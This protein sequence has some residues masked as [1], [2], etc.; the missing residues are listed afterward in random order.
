MLG[1]DVAGDAALRNDA[2]DAG[3]GAGLLAQ[4]V[5]VVERLDDRIQRVDAHLRF[6]GRMGRSAEEFELDGIHGQRLAALE[7][8]HAGGVA[9]H[10]SV[11]IAEHALVGIRDLGAVRLLRGSA[12]HDYPAAGLF[13]EAAQDDAGCYGC[14]AQHVM[15]A[16]MAGSAVFA[17]AG[18]RIV[19]R[20][21][22]DVGT[23]FGGAVFR[24][25]A[26]R[27]THVGLFHLKAVFLQ[28]FGVEL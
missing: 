16:A 15:T 19:F 6:T 2:V 1:D 10:G 28:Q 12:Q 25:V 17:Q 3:I 13:D 24:P 11:Q 22:A 7:I 9:D 8:V 26:R 18:Q 27:Q 5:D 20:H 14:G 23:G 4:R 21:K